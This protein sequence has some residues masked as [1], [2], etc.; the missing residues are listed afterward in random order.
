MR[1]ATAR[2]VRH[3]ALKTWRWSV[4]SVIATS[5]CCVCLERNLGR[6][7]SC[8]GSQHHHVCAG[9]LG[10]LCKLSCE[11]CP[12]D[13]SADSM[14][15]T[16]Y[17]VRCPLHGHGCCS[18]PFSFEELV[19]ATSTS[20]EAGSLPAPIESLLSAN[21]RLGKMLEEQ[22]RAALEREAC[23]PYSGVLL[24]E[25]AYRSWRLTPRECE[26]C[27]VNNRPT[28]RYCAK[29]REPHN[30]WRS[31]DLLEATI[32]LEG[33]CI[34]LHAPGVKRS[35]R[36]NASSVAELEP[37][38][39]RLREADKRSTDARQK[40]EAKAA[41]ALLRVRFA[42]SDGTYSALMCSSCGFGPVE[43]FACGD[44]KAHHGE[45]HSRGGAINNR[46]PN[47]GHFADSVKG[48]K[49]WDGKHVGVPPDEMVRAAAERLAA[50]G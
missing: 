14:R 13:L 48:W 39:L 2:L 10:S 8:D 34:E 27:Y 17:H 22:K 1:D 12:N 42:R 26:F 49:Q 29:A 25:G 19:A 3:R 40:R 21:D 32:N 16:T 45:A 47:C 7:I 33:K 36:F 37:W 35:A 38:L 50:T 24:K 30:M 5:K 46:C 23:S 43:H 4:R 15:D 28:F 31:I 11:R 18:S 20:T 6:G 44:L 41:M 9:C